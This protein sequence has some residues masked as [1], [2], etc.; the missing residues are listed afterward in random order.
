[1][2]GEEA[3][4]PRPVDP[5]QGQNPFS[6]S[7]RNLFNAYGEAIRRF[8]EIEDDLQELMTFPIWW[9]QGEAVEQEVKVQYTAR[10]ES[11][12]LVNSSPG[13]NNVWAYQGRRMIP[14][15][16]AE[17]QGGVR[18]RYLVDNDHP[19]TFTC[20]NRAELNN[21]SDINGTTLR[22]YGLRVTP[23]GCNGQVIADVKLQP[24]LTGGAI[25]ALVLICEEPGL[26][27]QPGGEPPVQTHFAIFEAMNI[28]TVT[29]C[30]NP[31]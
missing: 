20:W 4:I 8:L 6:E 19:G 29:C 2:P 3:P 18:I 24:I 7:F 25:G 9:D 27:P 17:P 21:Y 16:V 30:N 31:P 26:I 11:A 22:G 10:L 1:M 28:P 5:W 15:L 23:N 13:S 14:N 12:A